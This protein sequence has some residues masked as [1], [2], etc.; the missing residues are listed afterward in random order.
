MPNSSNGSPRRPEAEALGISRT[1][2]DLAT[3]GVEPDLSL[4]DL[5]IPGRIPAPQL[6]QAEFVK[7][8]LT[9]Q[10]NPSSRGLPPKALGCARGTLQ[11]SRGSISDS[12]SPVRWC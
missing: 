6:D 4:P 5:A 8:P 11:R 7:T 10:R 3:Q 9:I 12:G 2:F 1:T